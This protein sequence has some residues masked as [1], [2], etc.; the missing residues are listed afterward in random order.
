M[1]KLLEEQR[2]L[3]EKADWDSRTP[4]HPR[5]LTRHP[6]IHVS[7]VLRVIAE[8]Q[9]L[10]KVVEEIDQEEKDRLNWFLGM[11]WEEGCA[12]L[13]PEINW[14]PGEIEKD[15]V[16]MNID[17]IWMPSGGVVSDWFEDVRIVEEWKYTSKKVKRGKDFLA[18][19]LWQWQ[20][21]AYCA[22]WGTHL[23]RWHVC[24]YRGNYYAPNADGTKSDGMPEYWRYVVEY[25]DEE[26][27]STW[28]MIQRNK[29]DAIPEGV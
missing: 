20:G 1:P 19:L 18:D 29:Q 15:G 13:Y 14:Q 27:E 17:G 11:C 2:I 26:V 28:A 21:R 25:T 8:S 6:G 5:K 7:G 12:S 23:V 4:V 16:W 24:Y 22:G 3:I 9:G 10:L